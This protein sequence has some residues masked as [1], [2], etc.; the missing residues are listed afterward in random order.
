MKHFFTILAFAMLS[1]TAQAQWQPLGSPANGSAKNIWSSGNNL[2]VLTGNG[3]VFYRS[4]DAG[5]SWSK[6][7]EFSSDYGF[8]SSDNIILGGDSILINFNGKYYR[9]TDAGSTWGISTAPYNYNYYKVRGRILAI[10]DSNNVTL[11][12]N[13]KTNNWGLT[14]ESYNQA[15][16]F[17]SSAVYGFKMAVANNRLFYSTYSDSL[18]VDVDSTDHSLINP[19]MPHALQLNGFEST[20]IY[21]GIY[22]NIHYVSKDDGL[23][24]DTV[25]DPHIQNSPYQLNFYS[26]NDTLFFIYTDS[27]YYQTTNPAVWFS[28]NGLPVG[29]TYT[30]MVKFQGSYFVTSLEGGV[31]KST[32]LNGPWNHIPDFGLNNTA[33]VIDV[34]N[35]TYFISNDM[36]NLI[37]TSDNFSTF[38]PLNYFIDGIA[39]AEAFEFFNMNGTLFGVF[40][41]TV[42]KSSDGGAN[43]NKITTIGVGVTPINHFKLIHEGNTL[44]L[45]V[46]YPYQN[47]NNHFF[48]T[49]TDFG[50]TWTIIYGDFLSS[51]NWPEGTFIKNGNAFFLSDGWNSSAV[52]KYSITN[53]GVIFENTLAYQLTPITWLK[54]VNN[55]LL[56]ANYQYTGNPDFMY[57]MYVS[58]DNG[59]SWIYGGVDLPAQ[60]I[61]GEFSGNGAQMFSYIPNN[62]VYYSNNQGLNWAAIN[63][64]VDGTKIMSMNY[65]NNELYIYSRFDKFW[66]RTSPTG[67]IECAAGKIYFD[68]NNNNIYDPADVPSANK[69]VNSNTNYN[70]VFSNLEGEYNLCVQDFVNDTIKAS[71]YDPNVFF[72]PSNYVVNLSDTNYDFKIQF[73]NQLNDVK[74]ELTPMHFPVSGFA[75]YY[76]LTLSNIGSTPASGTVSLSFNNL[77]VLNSTSEVPASSTSSSLIWNFSNLYPTSQKTYWVVFDFPVNDFPMATPVQFLASVQPTFVDNVPTNNI[78]SLNQLVVSSYDPNDKTVNLPKYMTPTQV[79]QKSELTYTVR[80]QNTGNWPAQTVFVID[81]ISENLDLSTFHV[82]TASHNYEIEFLGDRILKFNFPNINLA[83][84]TSNEAASHGLIKYAIRCNSNIPINDSILNTAHI[85]FDFNVPVVTKTAVNIVTNP[86]RIAEQKMGFNADIIPNPASEMVTIRMEEENSYQ[87]QITTID[88]RILTTGKMAGTQGVIDISSFS[89]GVYLVRITSGTNAIVKKMIVR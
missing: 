85:F 44:F 34:F 30:D 43:W 56:G 13:L 62:G 3:N 75:N 86:D 49:S 2:Y 18:F 6:I 72:T 70:Y 66:K 26:N 59:L 46:Y 81:T 33:K 15:D 63:N 68:E 29:K 21:N 79:A 53:N 65:L 64:N 37:T 51:S 42:V 82:I 41:D 27:I 45:S 89:K 17:S 24:W 69:M 80:F 39:H 52:R 67:D 4:I 47:S 31:Y 58:Y 10:T 14:W 87:I 32:D 55:V 40:N 22:P 20:L 50:N 7:L 83:D 5:N 61:N 60:Y 71:Y 23:N 9:S 19:T 76:F 78:D 74:V 36:G 8:T 57:L 11:D 88:G 48:L 16:F 35:N 77:L 54:K 73:Q 12:N 38:Q 25:N 28:V 1:I 84:S